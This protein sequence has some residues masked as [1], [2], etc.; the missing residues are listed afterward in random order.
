MVPVGA[1]GAA[2]LQMSR[3][4]GSRRVVAWQATHSICAPG[5]DLLPHLQ[6]KV[7]EEARQRRDAEAA[8]QRAKQQ[9]AAES[10]RLAALQVRARHCKCCKCCCQPVLAVMDWDDGCS[11]RCS[12]GRDT[13]SCTWNLH[14]W[15]SPKRPQHASASFANPTSEHAPASGTLVRC[16]VRRSR[17]RLAPAMRIR[18][19]GT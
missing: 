12:V 11:A 3:E 17:W 2:A 13:C 5:P 10:D 14:S 1:V 16:S 19:C 9:L 8:H 7:D 15:Q 4:D 6:A 18:G